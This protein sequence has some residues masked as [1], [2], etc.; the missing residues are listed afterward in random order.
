MRYNFFNALIIFVIIC[1][2]YNCTVNKEARSTLDSKRS[3]NLPTYSL[4]INSSDSIEIQEV[5]ITSFGRNK[6]DTV[7]E[8]FQNIGIANNNIN[9]K[10][11]VL[12]ATKSGNR[13]DASYYLTNYKLKKPKETI[14][15]DKNY[16]AIGF[17]KEQKCIEYSGFHNKVYDIKIKNPTKKYV[18]KFAIFPLNKSDSLIWNHC[19]GYLD[20]IEDYISPKTNK[21]FKK[22]FRSDPQKSK[23]LLVY[24][25]PTTNKSGLITIKNFKVTDEVIT[26]DLKNIK[27]AINNKAFQCLASNAF[28]QLL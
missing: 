2:F 28:R 24:Y 13:F 22:N 1:S 25:D 7:K 18:Y 21:T 8:N 19:Y 5:T 26:I 20:S 4:S 14:K 27:T 12:E 10:I 9:I 11:K 15:I 17:Y 16:R 3:T 23:F 6:I